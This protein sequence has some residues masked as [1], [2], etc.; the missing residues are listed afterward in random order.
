M[1]SIGALSPA[2]ED[3]H[4]ICVGTTTVNA[5]AIGGIQEAINVLPSGGGAV[6]A[7]GT[8]Q[9]AMGYEVIDRDNIE[10]FG[11]GID[12]TVIDTTFRNQSVAQPLSGVSTWGVFVVDSTNNAVPI[13]NFTLRDMTIEVAVSAEAPQNCKTIC[14]GKTLNALVQRVKC[15]G[16][17]WE[18]IYHWDSNPTVSKVSKNWRVYDCQ[19]TGCR[20]SAINSNNEGL[21]GFAFTG[22]YS[23]DA[24]NAGILA[25]GKNG[26]IAHNT[27]R[28]VYGRVISVSEHN[29]QNILIHDNILDEILNDGVGDVIGIA[30]Y[31]RTQFPWSGG[32][33]VSDNVITNLYE[34][35]GIPAIGIDVQGNVRVINNTIRGVKGNQNTSAG[36]KASSGGDGANRP[37]LIHNT[38]EAAPENERFRWGITLE[39]NEDLIVL[40][41]QNIIEAEAIVDKGDGGI[42]FYD[43]YGN[44]MLDRNIINHQF[45]TGFDDPHNVDGSLDDTWIY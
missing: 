2:Q 45:F 30:A 1:L 9:P 21:D 8:W 34:A 16:G 28:E 40:L 10:I 25:V 17:Y 36:I 19:F 31:S 24:P 4:L 23:W 22:N 32:V 6:Y 38:L 18:V 39:W 3:E 26:V 41:S 37:Q 7:P 20:S 11:D 42:G 15:V 43:Y 29:V 44:S 33:I 35:N 13:E 27:F 5:R 12:K 14:I